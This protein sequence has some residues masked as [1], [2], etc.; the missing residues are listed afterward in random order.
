MRGLPDRA[1][2]AL[3]EGAGERG[4]RGRQAVPE[5]SGVGV[6]ARVEQQP[7]GPEDRVPANLGVMPSVGEVEERFPPVGAASRPAAPRSAVRT[8]R[9]APKSAAAAAT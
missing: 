9:S 5:V 7:R 3:A 8:R 1:E 6:G 2:L 4:E